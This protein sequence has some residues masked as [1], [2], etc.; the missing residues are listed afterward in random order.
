MSPPPHTGASTIVPS[1]T[2]IVSRFGS[3]NEKGR[4]MGIFRSLGALAR[5]FGPF[6]AS[7]GESHTVVS[8]ATW[9]VCR[10]LCLVCHLTLL[11]LPLLPRLSLSLSLQFT[12]G[13]VLSSATVLVAFFSWSHW[14]SLA[15]VESK[16]TRRTS[17]NFLRFYT[18]QSIYELIKC[19][20]YR[21]IIIV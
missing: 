6:A 5:A 8:M 18:K 11:L 21:A 7:T 9:W 4:V 12:G 10:E 3:G 17:E 14:P 15:D 2:T 13:T 1:L 20:L 19:N 16:E